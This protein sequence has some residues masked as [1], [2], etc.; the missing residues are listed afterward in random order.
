MSLSQEIESIAELQTKKTSRITIGNRNIKIGINRSPLKGFSNAYNRTIFALEEQKFE[1]WIDAIEKIF[2]MLRKDFFG[3]IKRFFSFLFGLTKPLEKD[4]F[5][6]R[7]KRI[8]AQ[9]ESIEMERMV[10]KIN[11]QNQQEVLIALPETKQEVPNKI[12]LSPIIKTGS[13]N[14]SPTTASTSS[15]GPTIVKRNLII[16]KKD[17]SDT[18]EIK[19][20]TETIEKN[21]TEVSEFEKIEQRILNKL[22]DSETSNYDIWLSLADLYVKNEQ[23]E[24]A[25]EVYSFIAKNA[26]GKDKEKAINGI[27][28]LD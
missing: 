23:P 11:E 2:K 16:I 26:L 15:T 5:E 13:I 7:M 25:K 4:D 12:S 28:G 14:P 3:T 24:K 18:G 22:K 19:L 20:T 21:E 17:T 27:I 10:D 9:K 8:Q 1:D 6:N